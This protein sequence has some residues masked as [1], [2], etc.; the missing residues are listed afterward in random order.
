[1]TQGQQEQIRSPLGSST[2]TDIS[3]RVDDRAGLFSQPDLDLP[4]G[5]LNLDQFLIPVGTRKVETD[6]QQI[7]IPVKMPG[8]G[9]KQAVFFMVHPEF[10][11][12]VHLL[13]LDYGE[14]RTDK[15][16]LVRQFCLRPGIDLFS[17]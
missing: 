6:E 3:Q 13:E 5:Q 15:P 14:Y 11:I 8:A 9:G 4:P 1:M 7:E 10:R 17:L 16:F 2:N 12:Q